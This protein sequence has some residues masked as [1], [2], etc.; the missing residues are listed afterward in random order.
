MNLDML[1]VK[2]SMDTRVVLNTGRQIG[3]L[4]TPT[5]LFSLETLKRDDGFTGEKENLCLSRI[6]LIH[7][8]H[9]IRLFFSFC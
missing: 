5:A 2:G 7:I 3:I 9:L 4:P 8:Y 6:M 1:L